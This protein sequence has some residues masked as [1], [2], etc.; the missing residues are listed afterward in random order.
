MR[1]CSGRYGD[2]FTR[3][4]NRAPRFGAQPIGSRFEQDPEAAVGIGLE[5]RE[6]PAVGVQHCNR[7]PI[8]TDIGL[9]R[10]R[11][12]GLRADRDATLDPG[13]VR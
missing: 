8:R 6:F 2:A 13:F 3:R 1:Q 5:S 7:C 10:L 11:Y 9:V 4:V 12:G